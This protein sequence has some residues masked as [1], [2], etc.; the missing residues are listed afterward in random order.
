MIYKILLK[1]SGLTQHEAAAFHN[2]NAASIKNWATQRRSVP[3]GVIQEIHDLCA[4]Q[5]R[6]AANTAALILE[7]SCGTVEIG[8]CVDD[9]EAQSRGYPAKSAHD[10]VIASVLA[11]I[12]FH[13]LQG[14]QLVPCGTTPATAAASDQNDRAQRGD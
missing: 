3:P 8:F 5:D 1:K 12:P 9:A 7:K 14:V 2:V 11:K 6:A 10:A 13:V 4:Q